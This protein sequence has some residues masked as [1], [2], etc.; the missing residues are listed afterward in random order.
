MKINCEFCQTRCR[1]NESKIPAAGA[2]VRCPS[3]QKIFF[4]NP[5]EA[6]IKEEAQTPEATLLPVGDEFE[7]QA[8]TPPAAEII[9]DKPT[10]Q[11]AT[12][13]ATKS[14]GTRLQRFIASRPLTIIIA[15]TILIGIILLILWGTG[16]QQIIQ[17]KISSLNIPIVSSQIQKQAI[18]DI[19]SHSLVGDAVISQQGKTVTLTLLV[20]QS[21]PPAYALKLGRKF[22]DTLKKLTG[23][24]NPDT[25][26]TALPAYQF[27]LFIYYPNG[28]EVTNKISTTDDIR[29]N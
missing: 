23:S 6:R 2:H 5:E 21:T 29:D 3:C 26:P 22:V 12:K 8:E 7:L 15:V 14:T 19:T 9:T 27:Q 10:V 1:I 24:G 28:N 17:S 25:N 13:P 18:A 16:Q 11:T 20:G 4:L